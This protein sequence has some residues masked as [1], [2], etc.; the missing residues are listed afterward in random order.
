MKNLFFLLSS[1]FLVSSS[2]SQ[3]APL[4]WYL[5]HPQ[6]DKVFGVGATEAYKL[7]VNRKPTDVIVA[8]I[9]S[10]VETDHPDLKDVIWINSDEIPA[11]GIDDDNNGYIDDVNGWSFLGGQGGDI[12]NEA[13]E[14]ARMFQKENRYF[15]G[16]DASSIDEGDKDRYENFLKI[17]SDFN[18]EQGQL[19]AQYKGI[20]YA[21]KYIANV[22]KQ[23]GEF[24]KKANKNYTTKDAIELKLQKNL[25]RP[26][27]FISPSVIEKQ[28]E[29]GEAQIGGMIR[30]NT[31]NADSLRQVIVG[32]VVNSLSERNY[33]CNR[34]EGPDAMHGTHVSGII[35]ATNGNKVGIDGIAKHAK[36]M[37]LRAVPNGDE[38]DKDIANAIYYAVDNGAKIINM[39]FGKYYTPSKEILDDAIKY[40]KSKDVLFVHAAGND[41]K[42]KNSEDSYPTRILNDG[43]IATN[44]LEVGASS[45]SKKGS[46]LVADFSNY[47]SKTVDLFAPGVDIYSTVPDGKY[48]DAS[49]TSMASPVAA[50]VAAIIRGYFPELTAEQ[51]RD[52]LMETVVSTTK[53]IAIPGRKKN[54][55][56]GVMKDVSISGGFINV[57]RAVSYLLSKEKK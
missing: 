33:G 26:F 22:K 23:Q 4:N 5:K 12:N 7:L 11:N 35:A 3:K 6:K 19:M 31:M 45:V 20:E 34:Y 10:G 40:A 44:W 37:V 15:A 39:S 2:F 38:R 28:V 46:K 13:M 29:G 42:D 24:S 54:E 47:G 16:K 48:E 17:K 55:S 18:K 49:G 14:I 27:L 30:S 21:S 8:V 41:A 36:I 32:D 25:K 1:F 56:V 50:G 57:E 43:T 9:D 53:N 51:V 52:V